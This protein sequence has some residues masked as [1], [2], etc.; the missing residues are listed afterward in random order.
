MNNFHGKKN[1]IE[2]EDWSYFTNQ[3]KFQKCFSL[4]L[5]MIFNGHYH[6]AKSNKIYEMSNGVCLLF[7]SI[8]FLLD[9]KAL[10][11]DEIILKSIIPS[12]GS[13]CQSNYAS[14]ATNITS[15]TTLIH[16]K[17]PSYWNAMADPFEKDLFLAEMSHKNDI[18][19][20]Q[21]WTIRIGKGAN[22][23]SFRGKYGEAIPPQYHENAVFIDEVTQSVSVNQEKNRNSGKP[24]FIHQAG[25]YTKDGDFTPK[26]NPFFSPNIAKYCGGNE[27]LSGSWG[28]QAHVPTFHSSDVLYFNGYRDC[29]DGV[30]EL[31]SVIHNAADDLDDGDEVSYLNVP[32]GG[33]RRSNLRDILISNADG[34]LEHNYPMPSFFDTQITDMRETGGFTTFTENIKASEEA[35]A[36]SAFT[37]PNVDG[38]NLNLVV[39]SGLTVDDPVKSEQWNMPCF[40]TNIEKTVIIKTGCQFCSLYLTNEE[41]YRFFVPEIIHWSWAGEYIYFCGPLRDPSDRQIREDADAWKLNNHLTIGTK[42]TVFFANEGKPEEENSALTFVHGLDDFITNQWASSRLRYGWAG[43]ARRDYT[44]YVSF[45]HFFIFTKRNF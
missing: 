37:M 27:C 33:V 2:L 13:K 35:F 4:Q 31:T 26:K 15:K 22:I 11:L 5:N 10:E 6:V 20:R 23:Y 24:Y 7:L 3:F 32:W 21:S 40:R 44:V 43:G 19:D 29:G 25:I 30:L 41:G 36:S 12:V 14:S 34:T 38:Q 45:Q 18:D 1:S 39:A 8:I 17:S 42:I 9:V 28:Q 16:Q